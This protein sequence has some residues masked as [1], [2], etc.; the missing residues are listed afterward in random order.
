MVRI[1]I[2]N[3]YKTEEM[4]N[5]MIHLSKN[6]YISVDVLTQ[7]YDEYIAGGKY[8]IIKEVDDEFI[9]YSLEDYLAENEGKGWSIIDDLPKWNLWHGCDWIDNPL[10]HKGILILPDPKVI[11]MVEP[12]ELS[13]ADEEVIHH[14]IKD[15]MLEELKNLRKELHELNNTMRNIS[16]R[17]IK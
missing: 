1:K 2:K 9:D 6:N 10:I 7:L 14:K 3:A 4:I 13:P 12:E 5:R 11:E 17:L 8:N 16:K 15:P